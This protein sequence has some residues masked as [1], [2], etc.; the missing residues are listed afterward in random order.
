LRK[1]CDSRTYRAFREQDYDAFLRISTEDLEWIQN[2]GFPGGATHKGASA[3]VEGVFKANN[4]NWEG[5]AYQIEQFLDAGSSVI[6]IG[7]YAGCHRVSGKFMRAAAAH[8]YDLRDGK[9]C[10]F[11]MFADTKTIWDAMSC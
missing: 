9:V 4:N 2:E 7:I 6:V 11:R 5:F 8:V 1:S 3:V 10:R